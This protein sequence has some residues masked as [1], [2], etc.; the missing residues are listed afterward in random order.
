MIPAALGE[1]LG[2]CFLLVLVAQD[3]QL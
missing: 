2:R 3:E 1:N